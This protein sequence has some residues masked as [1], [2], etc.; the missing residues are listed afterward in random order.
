[1]T[2]LEPGLGMGF[3]TLEI[4][5]LVSP[6][7]RVVAVDVQRRMIEGLK[8]RAR[9]TGLFDRIDSADSLS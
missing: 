4:A 8:R 1:M 9:K 3:F 7:G 2:V 6:S 5:R